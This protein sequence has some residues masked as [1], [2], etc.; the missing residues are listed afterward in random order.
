MRSP[1]C[2]TAQSGSARAF[3]R[4]LASA[5]A[6]DRCA[7]RQR[8]SLDHSHL[9]SSALSCQ[10]RS[11]RWDTSESAKKIAMPLDGEEQQ[12]REHAWNVEPVAG[13]DNAVGKARSGAGR[14]RGDLGHHRPDQREPACDLQAAA[15]MYGSAEGS[16]SSPQDLPPGRA[17]EAEEIGEIMID[18]I[19]AE[20]A[21]WRAPERRRRSRRRQAPP[22]AA[23]DR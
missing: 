19:Q 18:R 3:I 12:R 23:A 14:S 5:D 7:R 9:A 1:W 21:C 22:P 2:R 16:L 6:R 8:E 4:F 15:S 11:S 17:V 20:R 13:F 10:R